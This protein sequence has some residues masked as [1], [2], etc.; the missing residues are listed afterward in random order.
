MSPTKLGTDLECT[1]E[2]V[3]ATCRQCAWS[4]DLD[5]YP[6]SVK[7]FSRLTSAAADHVR[8]TGHEV[9]HE[10]HTVYRSRNP[11]GSLG[12]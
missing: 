4:R 1:V 3:Y 6:H 9:A 12:E 7:P 11:E 8:L 10:R 5:D 2:A